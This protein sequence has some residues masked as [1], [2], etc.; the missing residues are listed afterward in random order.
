MSADLL[1]TSSSSSPSRGALAPR[2][3]LVRRAT[4]AVAAVFGLL[5]LGGCAAVDAPEAFRPHASAMGEVKAVAADESLFWYREFRDDEDGAL[6]FWVEAVRR[7]L[8]DG[9]GYTPIADRE[10]TIDGD[11]GVEMHYEVTVGGVARG[12][13]LCVA[14][15]PGLLSSTI[16]VGEYVADKGRFDEHLGAVRAALGVR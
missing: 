6:D 12:Y 8:V 9:R 14:V 4:R 11:P 13:L 1:R 16:R 3:R 15:R 5:C 10:V 2:V 7:D